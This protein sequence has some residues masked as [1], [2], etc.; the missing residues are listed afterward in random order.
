MQIFSF[1]KIYEFESKTKNEASVFFT[2]VNKFELI[3]NCFIKVKLKV[4]MIRL[5]DVIPDHITA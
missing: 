3:L 4:M 2:I 5:Y 1:L